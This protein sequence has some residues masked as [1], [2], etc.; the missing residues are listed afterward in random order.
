MVIVAVSTTVTIFVGTGE[1]LQNR[2]PEE[3]NVSF[4][5]DLETTSETLAVSAQSVISEV[6][7]RTEESGLE[8]VDGTSYRYASLMGEIDGDRLIPADRSQG[9]S[10]PM[11]MVLFPLEDYN[12]VTGETRTLAE[13]ELLVKAA[14]MD[15]N[16]ETLELMGET[17]EVHPLG[18]LPYF[19]DANV[20]LTETMIVIAPNAETIDRLVTKFNDGPQSSKVYWAGD[21]YWSTDAE[22]DEKEAYADTIN[23]V[24][25]NNTWDVGVFYESRAAN[26]QE[27]YSI[28]GGFLF[29]GIFLGG[30]F[31]IGAVLITYFKQVSEGYDDRERVQVMQKV[32]LDKETTRKAT[33]SQIV[34][35]FALPIITAVLH[36]IFAYPIIS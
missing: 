16:E 17:F 1:T 32:G 25:Y 34:W 26:R 29:L 12:Q 36:T 13:D 22:E 8:V 27:W 20:H 23:D 4:V 18:E 10:L 28:N 19:L 5:T 6:T 14:G 31:M 35:M 9:V 7:E 30:L 24:I 33:R 2:F 3:N 11:M 21:L 15:F